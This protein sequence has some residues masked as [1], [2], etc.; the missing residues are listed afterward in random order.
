MGIPSDQKMVGKGYVRSDMLEKLDY[1]GGITVAALFRGRV[2][3]DCQ[4]VVAK[5]SADAPAK[6]SDFL[7]AR[8]ASQKDQKR[9]ARA[10]SVRP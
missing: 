9:Q 3:C 4:D 8:A 10:S 1:D 7:Q 2:A 5:R 6:M